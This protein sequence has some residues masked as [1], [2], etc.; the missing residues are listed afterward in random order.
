MMIEEVRTGWL[1]IPLLQPIAHSSHE[2][3]CIDLILVEVRAG[4]H[5]G[6]SY[7]FSFDCA[8]AILKG[9]V[10]Q[11]RTRHVIGQPADSI[12][13]IYERNLAPSSILG[14]KAWR[15]GALRRLLSRCGICWRGDSAFR[16]QHCSA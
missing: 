3:R 11:E 13:A 1:R 16:R 10:D 6:G 8:P 2:L 9:I 5:T 7:M 12:R 15:C 4:E 14:K